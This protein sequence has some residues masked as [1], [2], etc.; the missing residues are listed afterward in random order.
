M[1]TKTLK[2]LSTMLHAKEISAVE[3]T[4]HYLARAQASDLNAFLHIDAELSLAQA[5]SRRCPL[6]QR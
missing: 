3:L 4:Q 6:R 1:H 5:R 2:Q